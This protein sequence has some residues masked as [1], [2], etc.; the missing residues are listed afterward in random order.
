MADDFKQP[1]TRNLHLRATFCYQQAATQLAGGLE[2]VKAQKRLEEASQWYGAA[3][4]T[5][6]L[7][8]MTP[9]TGIP[10]AAVPSEE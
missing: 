3:E 6:A 10:V 7:Q 9:Q 8:Q 2:K 1:Q 4:V 5:K